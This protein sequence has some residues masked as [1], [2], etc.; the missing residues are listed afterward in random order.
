LTETFTVKS[1]DG[2]PGTVTVTI[3]GT[4]DA[5]VISSAGTTGSVTEDVAVDIHGLIQT[6]GT[7][8]VTD[9]DAGQSN[10]Q[11]ENLAGLYGTFRINSAGVWVY[12]AV[13]SQ[14][15]IQQL[16]DGQSL[17]E[18]FQVKSADGTPAT[19]TVT[20]HGTNDA[21]VISSLGTPAPVTEDVNVNASGN[22]VTGG[23]LSVTDVDAGQ[24]AFQ[25]A[26]T[27]GAHGT[28]V[29]A[30]D[31]TWTYTA[32]NN[33]SAIQAL[34]SGQS[35]TETFTVKSVDG[36]SST[37]TVTI[38]GTNDAPVLSLD[39]N[40]SSGATAGDYLTRFT[41]TG[42]GVSVVDS[43]VS[44]KDVDSANLTGATVHLTNA[45]AGDLLTAG[46]LPT[47]ISASYDSA[48]GTLTLSGS[49]SLSSYQEALKAVTFSASGD[50]P[51][52]IDRNISISV[53]D[54]IST[55]NVAT[56][57]VSIAL[58]NYADTPTLSVTPVGYWTF[59]DAAG[60]ATTYNRN[61]TSQTGT[62][63]DDSSTG[64]T[65]LPVLASAD[66]RNA[67]AGNYINFTDVGD[68]VDISTSITQPL[69]GTATMTFWLKTTMTG[70]SN[71]G[72][73]SWDLASIIGS[74]QNGGG[75]DIQ[76]GTI[77]SSGQIGFGLGNVPGVYST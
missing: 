34:G 33:Q 12:T 50:H 57:T 32:A 18:T 6:G 74:E 21:A 3:N 43:D 42:A 40:G 37:V 51:S 76:W 45:Q 38:L 35:L 73:N 5:A 9:V 59:N 41:E 66:Q 56:T 77:N 22:L 30:S 55:S 46:T 7:L 1:T 58:H 72:G 48:S 16:G 60:S 71:G 20:I 24:S 19:V 28:F 53:T 11:A 29:I 25:A 13:N 31:G 49:A 75:N 70:T 69:M 65:A 10:F 8:T 27:T 2:T 36:T 39:S 17:T 44:I 14:L 4:N 62:L 67:A 61:N 26:T 15:A 68:R 23:T 54:G 47:G 64:G 52:D 63:A